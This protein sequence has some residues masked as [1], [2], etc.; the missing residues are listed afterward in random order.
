MVAPVDVVVVTALKEELD[1]LLEVTAG[2]LGPWQH[3]PEGDLPYHLAAFD[4]PRGPIRVA[5]ARTTR[6][7]GVA[8]ASM[9]TRLAALL[10]PG[11]L[12]MCGVCAGHPDDTDLGDVVI[13]DRVFQHDHGKLEPSTFEGDQW[14]HS[15]SDPWLR[16]AQD[17]QGPAKDLHGYAVADE[18]AGRWWFL[19]QLL[20]GRDPLHAAA[21]RRYVPDPR[22]PAMLE[23][24]RRDL[25][26]ITLTGKTFSLTDAG[27]GAAHEREALHGTLVTA[28]PYHIHVGPIGSGNYVAADGTIWR[29]LAENHG[30]RKTLAVEMEAAAVGQVAHERSLPFIVVKGVMDHANEHK[31]DRYKGFAARASAEVL[32]AFLRRVVKPTARPERQA[33]PFSTIDNRGATIGQQIVIQG[34]ASIG[35]ITNHAPAPAPLPSHEAAKPPTLSTPQ[36][37]GEVSDE[38]LI[39]ELAK[40]IW[41]A[42]RARQVALAA[43]FGPGRIPV[44]KTPALFWARLVEDARNG[45]ILGQVKAVA[46][47]AAQAFPGNPFFAAYARP[48]PDPAPATW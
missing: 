2:L 32:C 43:G 31:T 30:M 18:E 17:M 42:E 27:R 7:A 4:G 23:T 44:M 6:M 25:G 5:A 46:R 45:A 3:G 20:A 21:L 12:A 38:R 28:R 48:H 26:Y 36:V 35:T 10:S 39:E 16:A 24:L 40:V 8:A 9:A 29:R 1:A 34:N 14:V 15:P 41:E 37:V 13:A 47:A 33:T 19:E 22:R 11:C